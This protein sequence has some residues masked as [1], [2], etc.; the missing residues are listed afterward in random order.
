[1]PRANAESVL[2][3]IEPLEKRIEHRARKTVID[4][5]LK[6]I[7]HR[8][9]SNQKEFRAYSAIT[10]S[11]D[12]LGTPEGKIKLNRFITEYTTIMREITVDDLNSK[13]KID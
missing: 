6:D 2:D 9:K 8:T 5:T 11:M 1:M 7:R 13:E 3:Y 12:Y 4:M 10:E